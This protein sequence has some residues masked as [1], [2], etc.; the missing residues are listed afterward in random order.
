MSEFM[1]E[2]ELN[3]S[4]NLFSEEEI[5]AAIETKSLLLSQYGYKPEDIPTRELMI[6]TMNCKLRPETAAK[7]YKKWFDALESFGICSFKDIWEGL[8]LESDDDILNRDNQDEITS[9]S[10]K[11]PYADSN[12]QWNGLLKVIPAYAGCGKDKNNRSIMWIKT[13][14]VQKEDEKLAVRIGC[15][16]FTAIHSDLNSL[17]NGITFVLDTTG[18][19]MEKKVGNEDKLQR[20]YQSIPLRP[21]KIMIL[22]ANF[23]KRFLINSIITIA[24]Y[25]TSEKV[26]D[27]IRFVDIDEV[28]DEIDDESMPIHMGGQG[29]GISDDVELL[30]WVK[31]RIKNFPPL[32]DI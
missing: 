8:S 23:V 2:N 3:S 11:Y 12:D 26:I 25:F 13:C 17:R 9:S 20:V 10:K 14:P 1:V 18:N 16:Y 28:K 22:G 5:S 19:S 30:S 24:S 21:Q 7:K 6:V 32:P 29:G 15:I 27:R 4:D 31:S